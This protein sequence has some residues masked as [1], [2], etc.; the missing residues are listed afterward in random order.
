M[1][2]KTLSWRAKLAKSNINI[3]N[4]TLE[5]TPHGT[6]QRWF[7]EFT[8]HP[9][10]GTFKWCKTYIDIPQKVEHDEDNPLAWRYVDQPVD[11][12]VQTIMDKVLE[13]RKEL[14]A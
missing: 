8:Y 3:L 1:D 10:P 13:L 5:N 7:F 9:Q 14:E 12:M 2:E 4:I 6:I 11:D